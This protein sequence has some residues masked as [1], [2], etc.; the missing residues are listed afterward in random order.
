[1][2]FSH[3]TNEKMTIEKAKRISK[4]FFEAGIN[5]TKYPKPGVERL[6]DTLLDGTRIYL[7]NNAGKLSLRYYKNVNLP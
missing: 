5:A 3:N 2:E 4:G 6:I 1:M 7:V